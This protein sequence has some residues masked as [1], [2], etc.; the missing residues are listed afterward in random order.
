M[1][2]KNFTEK[3]A[4]LEQITEWFE[5]DKVDLNEALAKF[6]RGMALAEDLKKELQVVEN[7]VEKI[8]Q[9]FDGAVPT[10]PIEEAS[11]ETPDLF[12]Q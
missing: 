4:E 2:D 6:E 12:S 9:K 8:K 3:L 1:S 11:A 5:S 7:K 10:G